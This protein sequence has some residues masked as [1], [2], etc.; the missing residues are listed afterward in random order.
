MDLKSIVQAIGAAVPAVLAI[1]AA[2]NRWEVILLACVLFL[3]CVVYRKETQHHKE[4]NARL[5]ALEKRD[6]G[7]NVVITELYM[8]VLELAGNRDPNV[9][10]LKEALE[11]NVGD[12]DWRRH[13][14]ENGRRSMDGDDREPAR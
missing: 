2:P 13:R 4:C 6:K 8:R 1:F 3:L 14:R 12:F 9:P 10:G 11:G 7:K 5:S